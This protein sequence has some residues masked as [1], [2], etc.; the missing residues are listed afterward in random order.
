MK[1]KLFNLKTLLEVNK[2]LK[3]NDIR[4]EKAEELILEW[5]KNKAPTA[6]PIEIVEHVVEESSSLQNSPDI[7]VN[8]SEEYTLVT[9]SEEDAL[10]A[11]SEEDTE[12]SEIVV[13]EPSTP[14]TETSYFNT[15]TKR[16]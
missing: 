16:L 10:V 1:D 8:P 13:E 5:E 11:P 4:G 15:K 9:P 3:A 2:F 7:L 14:P 12:V 6:Q